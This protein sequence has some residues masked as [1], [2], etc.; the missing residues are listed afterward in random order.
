MKAILLLGGFGTRLRPLTND[1]PKQMLPVCGR[2]M[3]EWVCEHLTAHGVCG[4]VLSLGYRSEA[5][6]AAYPRGRIGRLPYEIATEPEPRGTAGAVRFAA[7]TSAIS[8]T[9]LVL[10]GDVLTDLDLSALVGTHERSGAEATIALTP[11]ADPAAY[12]LVTTDTSGRVLSFSEKPSPG[13]TGAAL[14]AQTEMATVNAGTYVLTS[15]VLDRIAPDR[16]VSIEREIFPQIVADGALAASVF[17]AYWL[18]TGTPQQ[19]LAA[20]LDILE[21]RRAGAKVVDGHA[22]GNVVANADGNAAASAVIHPRARI[23]TSVIGR[24]CEIGPDAVVQRSVLL[25]GCRIGA[26]AVVTDSVLGSRT[27]VGAAAM[28]TDHSVV[29]AGERVPPRARLRAVRQP[30]VDESV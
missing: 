19:Y 14:A 28:L 22:V 18:D 23:G 8:E 15:S 21:G 27:V 16:P 17:D 26:G 30:A 2:P 10:N 29:G 13:S 5:F 25:D 4:V 1:M 6:T 9:F 7:Q 3:I 20:N 11:V 24:G 12:G